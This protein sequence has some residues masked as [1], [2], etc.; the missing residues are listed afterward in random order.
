M[1]TYENAPATKLLATHCACCARP[2]VDA[3]SVETGIG[4]DCRKRHGYDKPDVAVELNQACAMAANLPDDVYA[5]I[6][7]AD[8]TR[9][10][11]NRLVYRI[12]VEQ[13]G[14]L[15]NAYTNTI[16]ALGF[17]KLADRITHRVATIRIEQDGGEYL[18]KTPYS[19]AAVNAFRGLPHD[20]RRWDRQEKAWRVRTGA[21]GALFAALKR[22]FP[23]ATASGPK[24]LFVLAVAAA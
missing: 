24:G 7:G 16:R 9:E 18:V 8:T 2:L 17:E 14:P 22:A 19:E 10:A 13:D 11:C 21:K 4:P 20:A 6:A 5:E 1:S 3:T 15:V 23:G 12:A